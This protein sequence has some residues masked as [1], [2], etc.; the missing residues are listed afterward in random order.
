MPVALLLLAGL[1]RQPQDELALDQ[2]LEHGLDGGEVRERLQAL[3]A[4]LELAGRLRAAQHQH[5]EHGEL[6]GAEAQ[7]LVE[8]VPELVR[9]AG[10]AARQPREAPLGEAVQG[11]ADDR[12]VVLHDRVAVRRLVARQPQR[13][14]AQ[15][16]RVGGRA[17]LLDQAAE[18]PHLDRVEVHHPQPPGAGC[19]RSTRSNAAGR[20]VITP[21]THWSISVRQVAGDSPS[22]L[23]H[24]CQA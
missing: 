23:S 16:I 9:A 11:L 21:S 20:A 7:R 10:V 2:P 15:R 18:D 6:V 8:Q 12:L 19:A 13:V 5:R 17:L 14:E 22:S 24:V 4:L 1:P 3:R